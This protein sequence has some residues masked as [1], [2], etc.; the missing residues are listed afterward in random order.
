MKIGLVGLPLAGKTTLFNLLTQS[1]IETSQFYSGKLDANFAMAQVP[2]LRVDHLTTLY[3]PRKTIYAQIEI[4]DLP[5]LKSDG[6][7]SGNIFLQNVRKVDALV[8]VIRAFADE[9]VEHLDG[10]IDPLRDFNNLNAEL[11]LA[12]LD[13]V[14]KRLQRIESGK[15]ITSEQ[16]AEYSALKKYLEALEKEE[17]L[18][19]VELE[20]E[21]REAVQHYSFFSEMPQLVVI[22]TDETSFKAGNY[23]NSEALEQAISQK[24]YSSLLLSAKIE[25]EIGQLPKEDRSIFMEDLGLTEAGTYRLAR[26]MYQLLG[27]ISFFTVGEDEVRAWTIDRDLAAKK[28]AGKIHSDLERGFIRAEVVAYKDI[29]E[30]GSFNKC[31]EKGLVRLEGKDYPV[32]DGDIINVRFNV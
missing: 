6:S 16:K 1:E 2:D 18:K 13:F 3:K 23:L 14:E 26:Q 10:S 20:D 8:H 31:K 12:D 19:S 32:K 30:W 17:S 11:Y 15:K 24:G 25:G 27:Q 22:N 29:L 28:A 21:E 5:G 7:A 4:T 9:N